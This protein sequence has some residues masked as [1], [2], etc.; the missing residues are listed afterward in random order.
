MR[1]KDMVRA[2][3]KYPPDM[4]L[5]IPF[6]GEFDGYLAEP[7]LTETK[8]YENDED[9]PLECLIIH[10]DGFFDQRDYKELLN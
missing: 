7:M 5:Y 4:V 8:L 3:K 9:E 6:V 10:K 1:V 2:L